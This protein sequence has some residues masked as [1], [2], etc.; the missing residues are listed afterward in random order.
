M[1]IEPAV[2]DNICLNAHPVGCAAAVAEQIDYVRSRDRVAA[3][4]RVLVL[5]ASNGY[6]LAA[7]IVSAF[8]SGADT[9]GVAF[10]RGARAKRTASSGWYNM[11]SFKEQAEA[12]GHRVWNINGD[13]FS[14]EIKDEVLALIKKA[15]GQL[16]YLVYSIAAPKR[17]DPATGTVHNSVIKPIGDPYTATTIDFR[18]ASTKKITS[19]PATEEEVANTVKVMG[20]EDWAL[21]IQVLQ[22]AGLLASGFGTIA[23]S[24]IGPSSTSAI[25]REGTI[26]KAKEDLERTVTE[27]NTQLA[28]V[29]GRAV[30]GV[31]KALVT[32]ASSV[33]PAVPLYISLLYRVM[34]DKGLHENCIQQLYRLYHEVLFNDT[35][36]AVDDQGRVRMD[37][38]EMRDDVQAA[39][40]ERWAK[41]TDENI[42]D[43]ADI[44]GFRTEFLQQNGFA[45]PGVDYTQDVELV[46]A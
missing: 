16:D 15:F 37:D 4:Q 23:F 19:P 2:R 43:L 36:L 5:G 17:T 9:I 32:R 38:W 46:P 22:S 13:A 29:N 27:L 45:V 44:E 41:V 34:K 31:M 10:E 21:W 30:I 42:A 33:I 25:Y 28:A 1:I 12:A 8:G 6:G 11:E 3:P 18:S 24:Y 26:G 14:K 35:A 20:G 7:R 40:A 39:V